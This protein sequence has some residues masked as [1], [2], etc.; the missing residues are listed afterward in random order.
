MS[1]HSQSYVTSQ[2]ELASRLNS[3]PKGHSL[4]GEGLAL[5]DLPQEK[6]KLLTASR[7]PLL[8]SKRST[9]AWWEG[10]VDVL[11]WPS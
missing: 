9:E 2:G 1:G 10:M 6:K 4:L 7:E 8:G 11:L 3:G 5:P